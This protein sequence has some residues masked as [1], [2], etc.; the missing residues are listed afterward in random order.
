MSRNT[1]LAAAVL[2]L[3]MPA[4]AADADAET[5]AQ[6]QEVE[7]AREELRRARDELQRAARELQRASRELE[8]ASPRAEA[9]AFVT[10]PRRAMLG[11]TT[12][13][14]AEKGGEVRGVLV[15]GVTPGSGADKAGLKSGDLLLSANGKSLSTKSGVRP[16]PEK[17]LREV[18]SELAPGDPVKVEYERDGKR[19]SATVIASR[20]EEMAWDRLLEWDDHGQFDVLVPAVPAVPPVAPVPPIP[21]IPPLPPLPALQLAKLDADLAGYFKTSEG[22]L[23]VRPPAKGTLALKSGDVIQKINDRKVSSP[24]S[25][26]EQ[27]AAADP[28]ARLRLEVWRQ[29]KPVQVEGTLPREQRARRVHI[30]IEEP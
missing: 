6:R 21:P 29:G 26:L 13:A 24:V 5:A 7:R 10:N 9:Y 1:W 19:A 11:I 30:E 20:P 3:A 16:G 14:G 27:L 2:A 17:R 25:A 8:H 12:E 4:W 18:M 28:D 23:V 15:T 22:V